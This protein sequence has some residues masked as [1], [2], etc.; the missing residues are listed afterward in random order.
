MSVSFLPQQ[1]Q[2]LV[3]T[4]QETFQYDLLIAADGRQSKIGHLLGHLKKINTDRVALHC[5][6]P[7]KTERGL[8]LGEMHILENGRYCGLDPVSDNSVNFSIVCESS[9]LKGSLP[10]EIINHAIKNSQRLS[11]M[12]DQISGNEEIRI[13]TTLKNNN[14]FIAGNRLAY[15]GDAAGF[16]DPL[17]GEGIYNALLSALL[18]S[19]SLKKENTLNQALLNYKRKKVFLSF[20]KNMI[21]HFFQ[22]LIKRPVLIRLTVKFLRKSPERANHFIGIVGNIHTPIM[23]IIKM[24]RA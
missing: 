18:L 3:S 24:L 22:F 1:E 23:G 10:E 4:E 12:F 16:I 8:R 15:V 20:Q 7:R 11:M 5:Y 19:E 14:S 6:L 17:T 13:V 9:A 21:N 2:W